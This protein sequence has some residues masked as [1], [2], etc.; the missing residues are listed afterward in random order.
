MVSRNI[1]QR[2]QSNL[3]TA[4]QRCKINTD[5]SSLVHKLHVQHNY[6]Q[7]TQQPVARQILFTQTNTN[8]TQNH[9]VDSSVI[10]GYTFNNN[11]KRT[12]WQFEAF[13]TMQAKLKLRHLSKCHGDYQQC[14]LLWSQQLLAMVQ[15]WTAKFEHTVKH[16]LCSGNTKYDTHTV[17]STPH[18]NKQKRLN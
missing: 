12:K 17:C 2:S 11:K 5:F 18:P 6:V 4:N 8:I 1:R 9:F 10:G 16:N 15:K 13:P 7:L 3:T 14:R